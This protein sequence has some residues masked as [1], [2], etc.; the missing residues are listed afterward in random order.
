MAIVE[1]VFSFRNVKETVECS[2]RVVGVLGVVVW[3]RCVLAL[4][5]S[6]LKGKLH[7]IS[8]RYTQRIERHNLNLRQHLARPG[9]E[10]VLKIGGCR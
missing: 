8:K 10:I 7:V 2:L 1:G 3:K 9:G 4:Y 6:R 5:E